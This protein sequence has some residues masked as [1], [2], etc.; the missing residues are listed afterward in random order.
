MR[1]G[2][3][4]PIPQ[5][6][7]EQVAQ[8]GLA[9]FRPPEPMGMPGM[10]MPQMG[11]GGGGG[12]GLGDGMGLLGAGLEAWKPGTDPVM[13]AARTTGDRDLGGYG[14][15]PVD[16]MSGNPNAVPTIFNPGGGAQPD[17]LTGAWRKFAGLF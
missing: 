2:F 3:M 1:Q 17:F 5:L 8:L 10:A 11:G 7:A 9:S 6:T 12:F 13:A 4:A 15:S 14:A 16:P